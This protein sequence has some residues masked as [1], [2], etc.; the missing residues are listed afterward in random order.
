MNS[1]GRDIGG[2]QKDGRPVRLPRE[3]LTNL[4]NKLIFS[5]AKHLTLKTN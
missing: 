4:E 3:A 5:E 1:G 2:E